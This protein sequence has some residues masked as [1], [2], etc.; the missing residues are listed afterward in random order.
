MCVTVNEFGISLVETGLTNVNMI[1]AAHFA[2]PLVTAEYAQYASSMD[3]ELDAMTVG[4]HQ[5]T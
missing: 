4:D 5:I 3:I 1:R 2:A